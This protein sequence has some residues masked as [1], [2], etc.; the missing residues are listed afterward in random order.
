MVLRLLSQRHAVHLY[1][2]P[3]YAAATPGFEPELATLCDDITVLDAMRRGRSTKRGWRSL[4]SMAFPSQPFA[5]R[6]DRVHVFRL[7][8]LPHARSL[9]GSAAKR[10]AHWHLDLDDVE[11]GARQR[12]AALY[13][14]TGQEALALQEEFEAVR[15]S[16]LEALALRD[17]DRVYVCSELDRARLR[18]R[19]GRADIRVLPNAV[20]TPGVAPPHDPGQCFTFLFI[21]TLGY[22]PNE[23]AI[24]YFCREVLPRLRVAAPGRF[25]IEVV[26][27]GPPVLLARLAGPPEVRV[28]GPLPSVTPA[29]AAAD[30]VIVPLRAGGGTRIKVLEAFAHRRPVVSTSLGV[31]GIDVHDE[32][33]ALIGDT[34]EEFARQCLR[35]LDEPLLRARL[36]SNAWSLFT[37]AYCME[38]LVRSGVVD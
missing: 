7:A 20:A 29:C 34:P 25:R 3:L 6:F 27:T 23:D 35:L 10:R 38:A 24:G 37:R 17:F 4:L 15:S 16:A 18:E 31:E 2:V 5:F 28:V 36:A 21:G 13:G 9:A 33:H 12:L 11:S 32:E 19:P 14:E 8:M 22:F 30:A 26:G 1:V